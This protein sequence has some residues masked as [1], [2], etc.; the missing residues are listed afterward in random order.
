M[1]IFFKLLFQTIKITFFFYFSINYD[2]LEAT[3]HL[4]ERAQKA[5]SH[6]SF[7]TSL[8]YFVAQE[9]RLRPKNSAKFKSVSCWIQEKVCSTDN[10]DIIETRSEISGRTNKH[11]K[12]ICKAKLSNCTL[13]NRKIYK[14]DP[15]PIKIHYPD[16]H[17]FFQW[18]CQIYNLEFTNLWIHKRLN[19][20]ACVN[21]A[22][23]TICSCLHETTNVLDKEF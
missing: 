7:L 21:S 15:K 14:P 18:N 6:T 19:S 23:A 8:N 3:K 22:A 4:T 10:T 2:V 9:K 17:C 5:S 11:T 13:S 20:A 1:F 12:Q 16:L